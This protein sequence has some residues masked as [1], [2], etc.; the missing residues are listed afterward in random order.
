MIIHVWSGGNLAKMTPTEGK[1]GEEARGQLSVAPTLAAD[2][3]AALPPPP[4][5]ACVLLLLQQC[6]ARR[7]AGNK[8]GAAPIRLLRVNNS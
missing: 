5:L 2:D 3:D 1:E 6:L 4:P 7:R 8:P